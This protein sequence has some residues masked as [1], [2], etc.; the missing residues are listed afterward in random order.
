MTVLIVD[1]NA[2]RHPG[3]DEF[4][5]ASRRHRVALSDW[6][7]T[8]MRKRQA[9]GTSRDSL[10][11]VFKFPQQCFALKRT[12]RLLEDQVRASADADGLIDIP[13]TL[14]M[15]ELAAALWRVPQPRELEGT[16]KGLERDAAEMVARLRVEV[17]TWEQ[18]MVAAVSVFDRAEISLLRGRAGAP[19]PAPTMEKV[20][21]LLLHTTRDFMVRNQQRGKAEPI[22]VADAMSMFAFRYSL[23]VLIYTLGWVRTGSQRDRPVDERVND[24]I[25][26]QLATVG[27]FFNGVLS[28]DKKLQEV[29]MGSRRLL[30]LWGAYVGKDW[31][32]LEATEAPA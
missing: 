26:L 7:I 19:I 20:F 2:L 1:S 18:E 31:S 3:L 32:P 23:C 14:E 10:R 29:S 22:K 17:A 8:E 6:T 21:G 5:S 24:V 9:L 25:D 4:L 27:T 12:D 30:R 16:M 15:R 28:G 11:N 13:A